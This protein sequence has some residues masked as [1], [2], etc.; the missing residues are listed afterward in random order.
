MLCFST[1]VFS[2]SLSSSLD[3][4]YACP[5]EDV[6]YTCTGTTALGLRWTV[7]SYVSQGDGLGFFTHDS[8]GM[9]KTM[10]S[11]TATLIH[12]ENG[13]SNSSLFEM[14]MTLNFPT[15]HIANQ[16][17]ISCRFEDIHTLQLYIASKFNI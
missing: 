11:F 13:L 4:R 16:T 1:I 17:T 10:N 2:D 6:T 7:S 12:V 8:V 5:D 9:T 15:S 3:G 14:T